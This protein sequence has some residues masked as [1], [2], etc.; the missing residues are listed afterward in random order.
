MTP[1]LIARDCTGNCNQG[2]RCT[3]GPMVTR[4]GG[5]RIDTEQMRKTGAIEGPYRRTHPLTL[6]LWQRI[7]RAVAWFSARHLIDPVAWD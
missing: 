5:Q 1:V 7:R 4:N 3:C 2:R 6:S